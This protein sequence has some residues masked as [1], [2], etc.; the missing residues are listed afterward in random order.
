MTVIRLR[1]SA[2]RFHATPWGRHVNEGAVEWPPAPWRI[3]RALIATWHLKAREEVHE[4]AVRELVYALAET[5][6]VYS[7]PPASLSH[8]RHYM[9]YLEGKAARTT[10]VF[11]TFVQVDKVSTLLVAWNVVL[12]PE[13]VTTLEL[14]L[15]RLG[16]LGRA[17]A[18]VEAALIREDANFSPNAFPLAESDSD[19]EE[20]DAVRLLAPMS[21]RDFSRWRESF[22]ESQDS[23][24]SER[25]KL[26][27]KKKSVK[28][29]VAV[30]LFGA[31]H[32][33]TG[34]LQAAAW[35][36]PPGARW[37]DYSRSRHA[38]DVEP[39]HPLRPVKS[40]PT[41]ARYAVASTVLPPITRALSV[42]ERLHQALCKYSNGSPIFTGKQGN[43]EL[44]GGHRHAHIWCEALGS[45]DAITHV[46]VYAPD[47]FDERASV[48]LRQVPMREVWGHGGHN[49]QLVLLGL[50]QP[51]DFA[52]CRLFGRAEAWRS[53]TPFISTRHAKTYRNGRPKLDDEG[54][55]IG[56]P[57]H[58]LQRLLAS[59]GF[60]LP[61]KIEYLQTGRVGTR[62]LRWLQFQTERKMGEGRRGADFGAGFRLTFTEPVRGPIA[63]GYG[64][65]FGLGVFIP[66]VAGPG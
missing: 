58:D 38:F 36:L 16:Y 11:D 39:V 45:R 52:D 56:S 32:A 6:P 35:N 50:G 15:N 47:G 10:K 31:L 9:P 48:A 51:E 43:G 40:D 53:Y 20:R 1:F 33:D 55:Q 59:A 4:N 3:L 66:C 60:P 24:K 30:D 46:T 41:V 57:G 12:S 44:L 62:S 26:K 29:D 49:L 5:T 37:I 14:L 42:A 19:L 25:P 54:W 7:L 64:S 27:G 17:E 28:A 8:T 23:E 13:Q 18:L 61:R 2:G 21:A 34:E 22:L 65:H 63:L